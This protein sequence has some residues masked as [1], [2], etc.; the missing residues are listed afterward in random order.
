MRAIWFLTIITVGLVGCVAQE[1]IHNADSNADPVPVDPSNQPIPPLEV[2]EERLYSPETNT[3]PLAQ[4][5]VVSIECARAISAALEQVGTDLKEKW[6]VSCK[7][8]S[9]G[10]VV[11]FRNIS[12]VVP[13]GSAFGY[14]VDAGSFEIIRKIPG[15]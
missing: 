6:V 7:D 1:P 13:L 10:Y 11:F 2:G 8:H 15:R 5:Q 9:E 4:R 3:S 14:V 12:P